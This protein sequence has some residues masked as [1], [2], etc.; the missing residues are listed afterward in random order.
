MGVSQQILHVP[1]QAKHPD[2]T[3]ATDLS[4]CAYTVSWVSLLPHSTLHYPLTGS[5]L[6]QG[7]LGIVW[8]N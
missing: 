3:L 5:A 2:V 6:N 8:P 7:Y 4:S 1:F